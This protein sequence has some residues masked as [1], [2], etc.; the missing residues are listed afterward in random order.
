MKHVLST[1]LIE[2]IWTDA[3]FL[4]LYPCRLLPYFIHHARIFQRVHFKPIPSCFRR[5]CFFAGHDCP[6]QTILRVMKLWC[7]EFCISFILQSIVSLSI[8]VLLWFCFL[9]W[10]R[11]TYKKKEHRN[12]WKAGRDADRITSM[13]YLHSVSKERHHK[14]IRLLYFLGRVSPTSPHKASFQG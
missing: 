12:L 1:N 6:R 5:L 2:G 11:F 13:F 14:F 9:G 10:S 3:L 4:F 8:N 7:H